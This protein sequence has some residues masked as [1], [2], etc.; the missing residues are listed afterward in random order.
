MISRIG[1]VLG[2]GD[3]CRPG[4][5]ATRFVWRPEPINMAIECLPC[6]VGQAIVASR[7]ANRNGFHA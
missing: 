6:F 5:P 2:S 1:K 3:Y 4:R 7:M